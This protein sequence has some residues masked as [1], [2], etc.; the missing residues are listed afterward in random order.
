MR[1]LLA[2]ALLFGCAR[3]DRRA[4]AAGPSLPDDTSFSAP[5]LVTIRGYTGDAMEPQPTL[6]GRYMLFNNRND[7]AI[8]TDLFYARRI[9]DDTFDFVGP[10]RG[11]NTPA[12]DAV[13]S[14]DRN[15][16]FYFITA[17]SYAS[18]L[19]TVYSGHFA[20]G[21]VTGVA[22]VKGVAAKQRGQIYFDVHV[23]PD[24]NSLYLASGSF[25]GVTVPQAADLVIAERAGADFTIV[26][27]DT[28]LFKNVNTK[29]GLEYGAAVSANERELFFTRLDPVHKQ[30][31]IMRS[32]R[33]EPNLPFGPPA[34]IASVTGF[35]EAPA[36]SGDGQSLYFHKNDRG[37]FVLYRLARKVKQK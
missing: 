16:T 1:R 10:V 36:L 14:I 17:R 32:T 12:L 9:D 29:S 37:T 5:H 3:G 27:G 25:G 2:A 33:T 21:V 4:A 24:G 15:G 23:S 28:I 6:D 7:P 22:P 19:S 13:A 11:V 8:N 18:D 30:F 26:P 31:A 20:D 35:S 34:R